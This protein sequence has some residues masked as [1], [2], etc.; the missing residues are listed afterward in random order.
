MI[1]LG[2]QWI[3]SPNAACKPTHQHIIRTSE[4]NKEQKFIHTTAHINFLLPNEPANNTIVDWTNIM[5]KLLEPAT[6]GRWRCM[7]LSTITNLIYFA[8]DNLL[9]IPNGQ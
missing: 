6:D 3:T 2:P 7:L 9:R 4:E 5:L 1:L 8:P